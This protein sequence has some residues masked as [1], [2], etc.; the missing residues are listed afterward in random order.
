ML[1]TLLAAACAGVAT[2]GE[3]LVQKTADSIGRPP[4]VA[5]ALVPAHGQVTLSPDTA[6]GASVKGSVDLA[7]SF[8]AWFARCRSLQGYSDCFGAPQR[9]LRRT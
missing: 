5:R 6:P 4:W 3:V 8:P 1:V 2:G 9:R 7:V